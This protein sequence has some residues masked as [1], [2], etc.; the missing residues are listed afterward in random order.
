MI[1]THE[2]CTFSKSPSRRAGDRSLPHHYPAGFELTLHEFKTKLILRQRGKRE[3]SRQGAFTFANQ[4]HRV[5][6]FWILVVPQ[7]FEQLSHRRDDWNLPKRMMSSKNLGGCRWIKKTFCFSDGL[8]N[9]NS[10]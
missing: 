8:T 4:A 2:H 5:S 1:R 9:S 6:R 7:S 10:M 3:S